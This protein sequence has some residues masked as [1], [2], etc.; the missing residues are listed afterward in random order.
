MFTSGYVKKIRDGAE[1]TKTIRL[2]RYPNHVYANFIS[3]TEF[4]QYCGGRALYNAS[5]SLDFEMLVCLL[6][7]AIK[8]NRSYSQF[9]YNAR[10]DRRSLND[11]L[12]Y[13][14][15]KKYCSSTNRNTANRMNFW[16]LD[17]Y[18]KECRA[19]LEGVL[20]SIIK[21]KKIIRK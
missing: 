3:T 18:D 1:I 8:N 7:E 13:V 19:I 20:D 16:I 21:H 6:V 9:F 4:A 11:A 14:G 17:R 2:K 5:S 10:A 15:F 12:K